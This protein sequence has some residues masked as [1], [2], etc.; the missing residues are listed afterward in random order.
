MDRLKRWRWLTMGTLTV[1]YA[2]Y[3]FC[4]SN[5]SVATPL[6]I[7]EF[8]EAGIDKVAI[9]KIAS[10]GIL[11][12][13]FGKLFNGVLCDFVGG[14]RMF[15]FGMIA[16]VGATIL[17]GLG[18]G[19]GVFMLAWAINRSVQSMGWGALVKTASNWYPVE[20]YG[21][22]MGILCLSY[23]FGD[24]VARMFFGQL[25]SWEVGWRGLFFAA[26]AVL[27]TIFIVS[28]F[29]LRSSPKDL[30]LDEPDAA[31]NTV[32]GRRANDP[33][34]DHL[35]DLLAPFLSSPSFWIV[36]V[37]SFG[38]TIIRETFNFWT[39]LYLVEVAGLT[40]GGAGKASSLFPLFGGLSVLV[41]G[42]LTDFISRGDRGSIMLVFLV[43]VVGILIALSR[44]ESGSAPMALFLISAAGFLMI[45]PYGFLTGVIALDLGGKKGSSTAAGL[46]DSVGY[47]GAIVSGWGIGAISQERGWDSAFRFLAGVMV[48]TVLAAGAFW[49]LRRGVPGA[50][51][52]GGAA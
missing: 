2:G 26:A 45:G 11:F 21:T 5:L 13:A 44:L 6:I 23:L 18:A 36:C 31:A 7:G 17:F 19:A 37:I 29:T 34:P 12:Y 22:V 47:F 50:V 14:R 33:R 16:S 40:V 30:G 3:Y 24:V 8:A 1:G 4:R 42:A 41:T 28:L 25:V 48:V 51:R 46:V 43:P 35:W 9:G 10:I 52:T 32:F 15:L 39:P 49:W 20:R 38:L 27:G